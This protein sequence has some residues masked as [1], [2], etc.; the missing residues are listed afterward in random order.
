MLQNHCFGFILTTHVLFGSRQRIENP[1]Q[2]RKSCF[3]NSPVCLAAGG[4]GFQKQANTSRRESRKGGN[5]TTAPLLGSGSETGNEGEDG[6]G[7]LVAEFLSGW[8]RQ[9]SDGPQWG[10]QLHRHLSRQAYSTTSRSEQQTYLVCASLLCTSSLT[11]YGS[12][13][14]A[15]TS[16]PGSM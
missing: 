1:K 12:R 13:V 14:S 9:S 2:E 11:T 4:S 5:S 15:R 10:F 8:V 6:T 3:N 7:T 16:V